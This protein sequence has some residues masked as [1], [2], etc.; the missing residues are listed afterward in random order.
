[1]E[2]RGGAVETDVCDHSLPVGE[3][4]QPRIVRALMDIAPLVDRIHEI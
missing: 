3:R 1:M 2:A 4:I